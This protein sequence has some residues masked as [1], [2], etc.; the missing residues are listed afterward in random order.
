MNHTHLGQ[1]SC[2]LFY[3]S[4]CQLFDFAQ[5]SKDKTSKNLF[6]AFDWI[7]LSLC[8][9]RLLYNKRD[10]HGSVDRIPEVRNLNKP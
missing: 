3:M 2:S 4:F 6:N 10:L 9:S 1:V 8:T 7:F 5:H